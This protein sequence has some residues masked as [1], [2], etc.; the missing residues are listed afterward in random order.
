MVDDLTVPSVTMVSLTFG[1]LLIFNNEVLHYLSIFG[2]TFSLLGTL[3]IL[4]DGNFT[5]ES[6]KRLTVLQIGLILFKSVMLGAISVLLYFLL[7]KYIGGVVLFQTTD[8][9]LDTV[10]IDMISLT[11]ATLLSWFTTP[12][13]KSITRRL[14]VL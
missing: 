7:F 11:I 4:L 3:I 6:G 13:F 2:G 10:T 5:C 14:N 12:I 9:L 8:I 1:N